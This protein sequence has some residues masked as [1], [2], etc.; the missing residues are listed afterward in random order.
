M[1]RA[2]LCLAFVVALT[3]CRSDDERMG[4]TVCEDDPTLPDCPSPDTCL[5]YTSDAADE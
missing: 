4:H 1:R 5:L 2:A 3:G